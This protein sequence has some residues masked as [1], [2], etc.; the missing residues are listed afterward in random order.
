M[1]RATDRTDELPFAEDARCRAALRLRPEQARRRGLPRPLRAHPR[2]LRRGAAPRQRLRPAPG[3]ARPRPAWSR[4]SASWP[5]DGG[6]PTVFGD[7]KQTRD[8]IHVDDVVA[9]AARRGRKPRSRARSTSGP[10]SRRRARAGRASSA[11]SAARDDFEP[12]FA[13]ARDGEI[14]ADRDRPG[15]AP[16][17]ELGWRAERNRSRAASS[18][19]STA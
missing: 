16:R 5:R 15:R 17:S 3:P 18:R 14:A 7:G 9:R 10:G 4:S 12:E 1:E 11:R 6:R 19:R 13:P 2:P 8:Y